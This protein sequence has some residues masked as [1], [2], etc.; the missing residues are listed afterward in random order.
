MPRARVWINPPTT[1][2]PGS[3]ATYTISAS[4]INP[5]QIVA[6]HYSVSG[7]AHLG[8][9]Y[10]LSGAFGEADIPAGVSS[11]TVVLHAIPNVTPRKRE[12]AGLVLNAGAGYKIAK[13]N[14]A[15]VAIH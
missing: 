12:K 5:S 10:T 1:V 6:V 9:E 13:P 7:T 8:T 2:S 4:T 3:G 14:K 11:T 15:T